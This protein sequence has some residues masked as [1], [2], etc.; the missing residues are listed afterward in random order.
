MNNL[1]RTVENMNLNALP[2]ICS[3]L[4]LASL[5]SSLARQLARS[6]V[7]HNFFAV[8]SVRHRRA[9]EWDR[10]N[11]AGI[12]TRQFSDGTIVHLQTGVQPDSDLPFSDTVW[13]V[14]GD[15]AYL[16]YEFESFA[17]LEVEHV[18]MVECYRKHCLRMKR[19]RV[20]PMYQIG[21]RGH[22]PAPN[23]KARRRAGM[24]AD[25]V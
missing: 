18:G 6:A 20:R 3:S 8:V 2:H 11:I 10:I 14:Y 5:R 7:L 19:D 23:G 16:V 25:R 22:L 24:R 4:P 12:K 15:Q 13:V 9:D 1:I 17:G 21:L